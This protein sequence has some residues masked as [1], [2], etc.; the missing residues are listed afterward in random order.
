MKSYSN[1]GFFKVKEKK[2]LLYRVGPANGQIQQHFYKPV[3]VLGNKLENEDDIENWKKSIRRPPTRKGIFTFPAPLDDAFYYGH[4]YDRF[5]PKK[6]SNSNPYYLCKLY[7][8]FRS[9]YEKHALQDVIY[10]IR[11]KFFELR[12]QKYKEIYQREKRKYIWHSG[13][14]Y[15]HICPKNYIDDERVWWKYDNVSEWVESARKHLFVYDRFFGKV[16]VDI[17]FFEIFVPS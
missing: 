14:F 7:G 9:N 17:G 1:K 10:P 11:D 3:N 13:E 2:I 15:S 12:S 4:H 6:L 16:D 8:P 5:L